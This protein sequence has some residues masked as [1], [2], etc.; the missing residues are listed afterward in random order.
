MI[1][2]KSC[3]EYA[4]NIEKL[5]AVLKSAENDDY[6]CASTEKKLTTLDIA[7]GSQKIDDFLNAFEE[8]IGEDA[9]V[10]GFG[11]QVSPSVLSKAI[12]EVFLSIQKTHSI[13]VELDPKQ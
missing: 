3:T 8:I 9:R 12:A 4:E 7:L 5:I 11:S 13:V 2:A 1:E 10:I 6:V